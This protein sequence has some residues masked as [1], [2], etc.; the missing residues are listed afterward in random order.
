MLKEDQLLEDESNAI[1]LDDV[2]DDKSIIE[3]EHLR[4][5]KEVKKEKIEQERVLKELS[6]RPKGITQWSEGTLHVKIHNQIHTC[7]VHQIN[8][9]IQIAKL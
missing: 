2:D 4:L 3:E 9:N 6:R 8:F 1:L 5:D 7:Y